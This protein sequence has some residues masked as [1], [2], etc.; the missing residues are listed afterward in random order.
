MGK[1]LRKPTM[2]NFTLIE[3]LWV[4][5]VHDSGWHKMSEHEEE[6]KTAE[7]QMIH[8]TVGYIIHE[9]KI[10]IAVCQSYGLNRKDPTLDSVMQIPKKCISKIKKI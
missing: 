1:R 2:K 10:S 9:S 4:D 3:I 5:S 7:K 8:K 6:M